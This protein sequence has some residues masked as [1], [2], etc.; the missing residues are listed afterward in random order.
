MAVARERAGRCRQGGILCGDSRCFTGVC[1]A[2][3]EYEVAFRLGTDAGAIHALETRMG[4]RCLG[5]FVHERAVAVFRYIRFPSCC[6]SRG[7]R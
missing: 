7:P 4:E 5:R 1:L 6:D 2:S 3:I